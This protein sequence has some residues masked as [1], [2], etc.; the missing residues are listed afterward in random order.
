MRLE[1]RVTELERQIR[2]ADDADRFL[3]LPLP[4]QAELLE[5]VLASDDRTPS[6]PPAAR[7][8]FEDRLSYLRMEMHR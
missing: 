3:R 5:I 7:R 4:E 1:Q 6:L 2:P 8:A